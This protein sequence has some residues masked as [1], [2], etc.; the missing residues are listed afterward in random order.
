[1]TQTAET[2]F[3]DSYLRNRIFS[4]VLDCA[5]DERRNPVFMD[6]MRKYDGIATTDKAVCDCKND[7]RDLILAYLESYGFHPD[8]MS[9]EYKDEIAETMDAII[10]ESI[11]EEKFCTAS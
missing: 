10:D 1:M 7:L 11:D 8:E 5:V 3:Q 9:E 2:E 4:L 6:V